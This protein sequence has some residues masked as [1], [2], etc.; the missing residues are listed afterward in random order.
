MLAE[1]RAAREALEWRITQ[2]ESDEALE[3]AVTGLRQQFSLSDDDL[4]EV[5][6]TAYQLGAGIDQL[7][8]IYKAIAFDKVNARV[9]AMRADQERKAHEE[10]RRQA[11]AASASQLIS[12]GTVGSN[13]LTTQTA[14]DGH[15]TIRQAI[16]AALREHGVT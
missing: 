6:G 8:Y 3:R 15:M 13:G 11:G 4:R 7:P 12:S 1:E 5:I 2:R 14:A 9:Q 10:Q 16:E